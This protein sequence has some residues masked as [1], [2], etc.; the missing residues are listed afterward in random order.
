MTKKRIDCQGEFFLD[1]TPRA[2]AL[3][4]DELPQLVV[5]GRLGENGLSKA[6]QDL[7]DLGIYI[8]L[9]ERNLP[10]KQQMNKLS[11]V[12]VKFGLRDPGVWSPKAVQALEDLLFFMG[13]T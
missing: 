10:G 6:A 13:G 5:E 3:I 1:S 7:V 11:K 12:R 2:L 9:L 8:Y 4:D